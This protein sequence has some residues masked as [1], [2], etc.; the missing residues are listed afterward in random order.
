[1]ARRALVL[2]VTALLVL[3]AAPVVTASAA[4]VPAP[5]GDAAAAAGPHFVAIRVTGRAHRAGFVRM[6][7]LSGTTLF[8]RGKARVAAGPYEL[9][10]DVVRFMQ[11]GSYRLEVLFRDA[12]GRISVHD[13][14]VTLQ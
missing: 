7:V 9:G 2:L 3:V 12:H 13:R 11:P 6:R 10:L 1:M 5:A 14:A 4:P 8:A